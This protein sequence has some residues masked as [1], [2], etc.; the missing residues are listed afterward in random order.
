MCRGPRAS[1]WVVM[2]L[3]GLAMVALSAYAVAES[4]DRTETSLSILDL[5]LRWPTVALVLSLVVVAIFHCEIA[6]LI[7]RVKAVRAMGF[8]V[9]TP[10]PANDLDRETA[11]DLRAE[12]AREDESRSTANAEPDFRSLAE[13]MVDTAM[14]WKFH[15]LDNFLAPHSKSVLRF[16]AVA[17]KPMPLE[18]VVSA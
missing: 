15:F 4:S 9:Q 17:E 1:V 12:I 3:V 8:E 18:M 13:E 14:Q 2:S 5:G 6:R 16:I 10:L 7:D 11:A